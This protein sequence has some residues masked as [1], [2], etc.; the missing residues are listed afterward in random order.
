MAHTNQND[1]NLI[2]G[3]CLSFLSS[4]NDAYNNETSYFKIINPKK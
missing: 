4:K 3:L 2:N 1:T